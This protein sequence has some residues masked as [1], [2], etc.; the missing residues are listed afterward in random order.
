MSAPRIGILTFHRCINYGSY[1]QARCLVEG[2]RRRGHRAVLLDH[3]SARVNRAEWRCALAPHLPE[4]T[5]P[6]DR[7]AYARKTRAFLAAI[8]RL[9][10]SAP[11][12]LD[13][14]GEAEPHDL[15]LVG[16]DEVWNLRHPWYGRAPLFYGQGAPAP[17]LAAYAAS[18][19]NQPAAEGLDPGSAALLAR[20]DAISVRDDN[21]R[22][23]IRDGLGRAPAFVLDPCLQFPAV[24]AQPATAGDYAVVYG[25][26]FPAWFQAG[27][28]AWA[29]AA[30]LRLV[31]FGYRNDWADAQ[32]LDAGP[33]DF[34]RVVAGA[35]AVATTF[36]HGC[37][38]AL[39]HGKPLLC[40]AS[41]YRANKV[42]SLMRLIGEPGRLVDADAPA[43]AYRAAL[44]TP[45]GPGVDRRLA[46]LRARSDA[47][48][49]RALAAAP[50]HAPDHAPA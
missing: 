13:R 45:P 32:W 14:P 17:R 24:A 44:D 22:A 27:V 34:P 18:F 3:R 43:A 37:V 47:F 1:W 38:F 31:S 48:L 35:A 10:L 40:A 7:R 12:D 19:G 4:P 29:R 30:G 26:G 15:V 42:T 36:F 41:D 6:E 5:P 25:H 50:D 33:E 28:R 11:F 49:D 20:F 46:V 8:E 16:S 2:L 9:P 21:S 39:V 23:L